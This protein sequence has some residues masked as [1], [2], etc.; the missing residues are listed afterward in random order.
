[1]PVGALNCRLMGPSSH[2]RPRRRRSSSS[3]VLV[4]VVVVVVVVLLVVAKARTPMDGPA[5]PST[6][7]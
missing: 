1:M 4:V 5:A 7:S 6:T 2:C 3:G